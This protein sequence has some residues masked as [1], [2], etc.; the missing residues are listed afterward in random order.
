MCRYA[1]A[2]FQELFVR[3]KSL[4]I[5]AYKVKEEK[6]SCIVLLSGNLSSPGAAVGVDCVPRPDIEFD[7]YSDAAILADACFLLHYE[8]PRT[9]LVCH[10]CFMYLNNTDIH[11]YPHIVGLLI[12]FFH[13]LSTSCTSFEKSYASNT[14][15]I[16][17]FF[18][19]FGLQKFGFSNYFEFGSTDSACI[20]FDRFPFVTIYNSG[21]L[22][23]LESSLVYAIPD[24][25]KYFTLRDR[26]IKSS[27]INMKRGS[28]FF[29]VSSSKS[30]SEFGY[31]LESGIPRTSD[32]FSI[33][34]HLYG[35]RAH[36]HDSSCIIGT[37]TVPTSKSSLLFC[38]DS[39]DI[40]SSS[41]GLALTSSW[42]PRNFQDYLW[43]PSSANL[44]P[45]LNVRVRKMQNI[46]SIVNLE[47][48]IGI[49]HVYC[50]LP[51]E[52]LSIII[53]YFSLPDWG[54]YSGDRVSFGEQGDMVQK[55]EMSITY[56]F[57]ILD[58]NLILPVE[59]N[60]HQFLKVE[61]LQLYCCFFE[62]SGFDDVL[63][64]IR[65]E[66]LVPIHKLAKRNNCLNLFGRDLLVSFLFYKNDMLGLATIE[67]NTEFVT[68][69][70]VAP[71]NADVWVRIPY[72]SEF[73]CK[74]SSSS[75]CFMTDISGCHIIAE[76]CT[77]TYFGH[78]FLSDLLLCC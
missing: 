9:D 69:S 66:C 3:M 68:S 28:K 56:K 57:E 13:R 78:L 43:G 71:L 58:S 55:N 70:L 65:A 5:Q 62:N 25:R 27:K 35:I 18:S 45:I 10:K 23:N 17:K 26:K 49:Q 64:N 8:S 14:A 36:F 21:S 24:W 59:S 11:C 75:I 15:D 16:S 1:S 20:P 47:V 44:S 51:S 38:E 41:E 48:C 29:H 76:G 32:I 50:M 77:S 40:L 33:E 61:M 6:E 19:S 52:Y 63:K 22:G 60:E 4:M 46:S 53:G 39:M 34:L 67:R 31:F 72:G 7:Q 12:G 74:S 42:G 30:K 73:N 37:V 54:G 2:E